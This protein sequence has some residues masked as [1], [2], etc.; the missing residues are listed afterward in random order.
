[1]KKV[2]LLIC[3]L[4]SV[5][6]TMTAKKRNIKLNRVWKCKDAR[7][8]II[9]PEVSHDGNVL[10]VE[11]KNYI[12]CLTIS[13]KNVETGNVVFEEEVFVNSETSLFTNLCEGEYEIQITIGDKTYIGYFV[14][15]EDSETDKE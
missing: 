9:L 7:S 10:Y 14:I 6:T 13:I 12:P 8:R 5:T 11:S 3:I 15:G 2:V 4:M 1:M